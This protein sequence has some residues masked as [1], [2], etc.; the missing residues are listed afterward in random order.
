MRCATALLL[1]MCC[2]LLLWGDLF[3]VK[4]KKEFRVNL[5]NPEFVSGVLKTEEGG[6][7]TAE[8]LRI[9]GKQ[10]QYI[11]RIENGHHIQKV[12]VEGDLMLEFDGALFVGKRLEFNFTD[13]TGTLWDGKTFVDYWF[14]GGDKVLLKADGSYLV[15]DA[16]ITTCE[17]QDHI[18]ELRASRAKI[19]QRHFLS[20]KNLRLQFAHLPFFWLPSFK[21]NLKFFKEVPLQY[22]LSREKAGIRGRILSW[23]RCSGYVHL[24]YKWLRGL[25]GA[26]E[27]EWHSKDKKTLLQAKSYGALDKLEQ[28][29]RFHL[30]GTLEHRSLDERTHTL[31]SYDKLSDPG[32]AALS[33]NEEFDV[34][35]GQ[36]TRALFTHEEES[37]L[38]T[39]TVR[40]R[41]NTFQNVLQELPFLK[42]DIRPF[43][44][45]NTGILSENRVQGG[46]LDY[47][48]TRDLRPYFPHTHVLRLQ[49]QHTLL[50]PFH[51]PLLT[52]TPRISYRGL[53]SQGHEPSQRIGIG[54]LSYGA[55]LQSRLQGPIGTLTHAII[56]YARYFRNVPSAT[57]HAPI[58]RFSME[59]F[60]HR[61]DQLQLGVKQLFFADPF[62]PAFTLDTYVHRASCHAKAFSRPFSRL[63]LHAAIQ[64][65]SSMLRGTCTW[66]VRTK[67][68]DLYNLDAELTVNEDLALAVEL[69]H[70]GRSYL[71]RA[72]HDDATL[73]VTY[74]IEELIHSPLSDRRSTVLTRLH[75]RFAPKWTLH[76][77]SHHG[78]HR[79]KQPPYHAAKLDVTRLLPCNWQLALSYAHS[80]EEDRVTWNFTFLK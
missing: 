20:A 70:R 37:V 76:V 59:D 53:Y 57:S 29:K 71:R 49:T 67:C 78:W 80:P 45:R 66:N 25:N 2:P 23:K 34:P 44:W 38:G 9:Q 28:K 16:Y 17:S 64:G 12:L 73:E 58:P 39:L 54:M 3:P 13:N 30:Q 65:P 35:T 50:R 40:P 27:T 61:S 5:R 18:W 33:K 48:C 10:I 63:W 41:I 79:H 26:L 75:F 52:F 21:L 36:C 7:I 47:A 46:V 60:M 32:I 43:E 31:L 11:S 74:P 8:G 56:P 72:N 19:T 24:E 4:G 6:I 77:E 42:L 55:Q 68:I 1:A 69:R 15:T 14:L 22:K 62:T 51:L